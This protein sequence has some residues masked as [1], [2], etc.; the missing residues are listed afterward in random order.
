MH[1]LVIVL[2][3]S[4]VWQLRLL[5]ERPSG[6]WAERWYRA[7]FFF[8]L[9]PLLLLF[10]AIAVLCMGPRGEMIGIQADWIGNCIVGGGLG[11]A[12][13]SCAQLALQ[14][15]CCLQQVRALEQRAIGDRTQ[16]VRILPTSQFFCAQ[17][18][19]WQPELVVS[20]GLLETLS[21]QHLAAVLAHERAHAH[22]RDTFWF[23]WLG[24]L[25][26]IASWLP[27]TEE[28]WQELLT[29]R[30]LRADRWAAS[31]VD[32]LAIAEALI[33]VVS[34]LKSL[35]D[36]HFCAAFARRLPSDR[37]QE[38]IE[39]LLQPPEPPPAF[40]WWTWSWGILVFFP[41]ILIPF[42]R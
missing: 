12:I 22:Y 35:P 8:L 14:G 18:G 19:F 13:A 11:M 24:G 28:L 40:P 37:L 20:T 27:N 3:L 34:D 41:L 15:W 10:A 32:A 30:E 21:P 38:R 7:L 9:P 33:T 31:R 1:S 6:N 23:F 17:I 5:W 25:R 36:S 2:F 4:L 39:A 16:P 42:H 26:R 29:L